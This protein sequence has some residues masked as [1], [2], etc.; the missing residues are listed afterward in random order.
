MKPATSY[1][2]A[3]CLV[4]TALIGTSQAA[5]LVEAD[6]GA[7]FGGRGLAYENYS[8]DGTESTW[9]PS[10]S[11][12]VGTQAKNAIFGGTGDH[13]YTFSYTPSLCESGDL[14]NVSFA[15]GT[16]LGNENFASGFTGGVPGLYN[17]YATWC[18]STNVPE[19]N[20]NFTV[21]NEG[22]DISL[23]NVNQYGTGPGSDTWLLV[24]EGVRLVTGRTYT[25]QQE[26][27]S[28]VFVSMRS[29]GVMWELVEPEVPV[30]DVVQAGGLT[31]VE[32]GGDTDEYSIVLN[33]QPLET[34]VV[35]AEPCD[36]NQI[37]LNGQDRLELT[38][39]PEDWDQ[40]RIITVRAVE[41]SVREPETFIWVLHM[42]TCEDP[43]SSWAD[44]FAGLAKI[45]VR[46]FDVPSVRLVE[47][48]G[49][50][51]VSEEGPSADSYT[52]KLLYPPTDPVTL[53]IS[54]DGQTVVDTGA[55]PGQTAE[56]VFGVDDW[57]LEQ[58][59]TVFAVDDD[60]L[61]GDH[62]STI[63]HTVSSL[64]GGYDGLVVR[65]I[66]VAVDDNECG[67]WGY[68][69]LDFDKDCRVG[70]SDFVMFAE[71]WLTCTQPY[72]EG[73]DDLR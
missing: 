29:H 69:D 63:T 55:G 53:H 24:A 46:D 64:D 27:I 47:S 38:F 33:T 49:A 50:T 41:D 62:S 16:D 51:V 58:A 3:V 56:L 11:T 31:S 14:D 20:V 12:A 37:T 42:T 39:T 9:G 48:D 19:N 34:I 21:T 32:E 59:V 57:D 67:A 7:I 70:L 23:L 26:A 44:A 1:L 66:V 8:G 60:V 22:D 73:C 4:M 52:A 10:R 36:P 13:I 40:E 15:A 2:L 30:A 45:S 65:D 54:T 68:H 35:T 17:V 61:E 43:N 28:K 71:A 72:G 25:V 6:S 5:F 18:D